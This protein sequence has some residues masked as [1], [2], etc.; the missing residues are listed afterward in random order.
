MILCRHVGYFENFT[1]DYYSMIITSVHKEKQLPSTM[2]GELKYLKKRMFLNHM[3]SEEH[4]QAV[5]QDP[6]DGKW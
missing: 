4:H 6:E 5:H 2:V 3:Q 1:N